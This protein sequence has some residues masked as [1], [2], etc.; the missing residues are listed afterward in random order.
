MDRSTHWAATAASLV[1]LA[2]CNAVVSTEPWF[3]E[4]DAEGD[5]DW[6]RV[7]AFHMDEYIGLGEDAPERF[8]TWLQKRIFNRVPFGAVHPIRPEP[9]PHATARYYAE[10][11]DAA[12]IDIVCLG[13]GVNGHIAFNDPPRVSYTENGFEFAVDVPLSQIMGAGSR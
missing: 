13:I 10:E 11:L 2:G 7:E 4:A 1:L 6:S 3:T 8:A 5:I 12:P 9:D